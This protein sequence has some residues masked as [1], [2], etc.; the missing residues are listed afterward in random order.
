[1]DHH[2]GKKL[3]HALHSLRVMGTVTVVEPNGRSTTATR[4]K[5]TLKPPEPKKHH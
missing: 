3:L 5:L 2:A 4:F 1:M